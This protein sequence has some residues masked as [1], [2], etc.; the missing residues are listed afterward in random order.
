MLEAQ[1]KRALDKYTRAKPVGGH[2]WNFAGLNPQKKWGRGEKRP[3]NTQLKTICWKAG[4]SF[5]KFSCAPECY[6][7][8]VYR[9]RKA[10]EIARNDAGGNAQAA[11]EALDAKD[12]SRATGAREAYLSGKLPPAHES[13]G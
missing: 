11:R 12:Y 7:G 8:M 10:W 6:Y 4:D 5:V 3:W 9:E 13:V 1:I 2:I